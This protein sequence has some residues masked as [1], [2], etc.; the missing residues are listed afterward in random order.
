MSVARSAIDRAVQ[1]PDSKVPI[2][3]W[4]RGIYDYVYVALHPFFRI[5]K[6]T[7]SNA[8]PNG[9]SY[10]PLVWFAD[11]PEDFGDL[12]KRRGEAVAWQTVHLASAPT[13]EQEEAYYAIW[14]LK[15]GDI[16]GRAN[17]ELRAKIDA[18][19]EAETLY[20][21]DEDGMAP[22]MEATVG[23]FL[24]CFGDGPI[25][26]WD[27]TRDNSTVLSLSHLAADR[28]ATYLPKAFTSNSVWGLHLPGQGV[29]LTWAFED[30]HALIALTASARSQG[31]PEELFEGWYV[32]EAAYAH[33]FAPGSFTSRSSEYFVP[34]SLA[35]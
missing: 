5:R 34:S 35:R 14:L 12:T 30:T 18:Y 11:R 33:L 9:N 10:E 20:F 16:Y 4:W 32:G 15:V 8:R 21:P 22:I 3:E 6:P 1:H 19:C 29:L 13:T 7:T 26:A 17:K 28:P 23:R 25:T 24:S 27:E 31:R 2:L